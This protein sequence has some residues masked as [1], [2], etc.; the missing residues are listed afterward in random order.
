[1]SG[2]FIFLILIFFSSILLP[3]WITASIFV[4][5]N[6]FVR[7]FYESIIPMFVI[8][9]IHG[10]P[11]LFSGSLPYVGIFSLVFVLVINPIA[12]KFF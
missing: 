1:M 8:D 7:N 5:S 4:I 3:F 6:I 12:R 9:L 10:Q 2:R 11:S